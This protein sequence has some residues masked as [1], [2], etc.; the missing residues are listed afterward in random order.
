[1]LNRTSTP[2]QAAANGLLKKVVTRNNNNHNGSIGVNRRNSPY[3]PT[4]KNATYE[5][6]DDDD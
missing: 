1:M 5:I 4:N 6:S 2:K 3:K